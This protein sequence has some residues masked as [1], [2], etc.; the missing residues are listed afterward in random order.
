MSAA[1]GRR[2]SWLS[3]LQLVVPTAAF[4]LLYGFIILRHGRRRIIEHFGVMKQPT[5]IWI[6]QQITEAFPWDAVPRYL[7]RD[8]DSAYGRTTR[9]RLAAMGITD[10]LTAPRAPW[11]SLYVERVI[12]SIRRECLDH[13]IVLSEGQLRRIL[14]SYPAHFDEN[15]QPF[16][17]KAAT[18]SDPK[19][20]FGRAS[21]WALCRRIVQCEPAPFSHRIPINTRRRKK[22]SSTPRSPKAVTLHATWELEATPGF[23]NDRYWCYR[24]RQS[25]EP[26][27]ESRFRTSPKRTFHDRMLCSNRMSSWGFLSVSSS[28]ESNDEAHLFCVRR[29][30]KII[31]QEGGV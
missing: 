1:W 27:R 25:E 6:A 2:I 15:G 26:S 28:Q 5:A 9:E 20:R 18:Y 22:L 12:G 29:H 10:V 4:A 23:A 21:I 3:P 30:N 11:Q 8:R 24:S 17:R 31:R 7:S 16:R 19:G 14:V 13:V